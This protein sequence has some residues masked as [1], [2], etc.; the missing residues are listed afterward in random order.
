M[1]NKLL[2]TKVETTSEEILLKKILKGDD[3][4]NIPSLVGNMSDR[5]LTEMIKDGNKLKEWLT[6]N[7]EKNDMYLMSAVSLHYNLKWSNNDLD[8]LPE[9]WFDNVDFLAIDNMDYD[10]DGVIEAAE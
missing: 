1:Q 6:I 4:D 9:D 7:P 8:T 10:E 2:N 5:E 3:S